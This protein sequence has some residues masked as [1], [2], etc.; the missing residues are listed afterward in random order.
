[1]EGINEIEKREEELR[2]AMLT[3][4]VA[5]RPDRWGAGNPRDCDR[6]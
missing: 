4:D 3:T 2:Q 5:Q 1:M 6:Q